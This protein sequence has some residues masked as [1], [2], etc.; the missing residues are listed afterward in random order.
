MRKISFY[1]SLF[2]LLLGLSGSILLFV[3]GLPSKVQNVEHMNIVTQQGPANADEI[4]A[5]NKK[6]KRRAKIG[7]GMITVCFTIQLAVLCTER[8]YPKRN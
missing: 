5:S 1:L 6:V 2:A 4:E 8:F 3:Y 7:I